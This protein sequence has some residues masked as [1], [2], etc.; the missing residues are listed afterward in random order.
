MAKATAR[1]V[2]RFGP[3]VAGWCAE[4]PRLV[5]GLTAR[6]G[7]TL[8]APLPEGA[9]SITLRCRWPDGTPAVL[10]LSPDR[11]LLVEQAD[12]LRW[13]AASGRVPVVVALDGAAGALVMTEILPGTEAGELP[14]ASLPERW[15]DLLA[16][17]H[18]LAPPPGATRTLGDR[19][20]EAFARVGRRLIEPAV[21]ARL[22]AAAWDRA[23]RRCDRLLATTARPVLLHGD[24]HPGNALDGGAARGLMAIDPKV[25]VGDPCFDAVDLVVAGA[26]AEG[27]GARCARV[28]AACGL[29]GERLHEW[30]RVIAA[31]AAVAQLAGGGEE[32]TTEE[33]LALTR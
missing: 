12:M 7:L 22:D 11:T 30:S 4:V 18:G 8:G 15:A 1:L 31:F 2:R 27:V 20:E 28:A 24:L 5:A 26:G 23:V 29:D 14:A 19:C 13:L 17:L 21:G 25:C 16:A 6:W 9:A 10:K 33:L 32:S 3:G